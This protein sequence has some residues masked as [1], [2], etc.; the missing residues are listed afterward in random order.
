MWKTVISSSSI[1]SLAL[2]GDSL[3]YA[4]LPV[5]AETFGL[6]FAMVG[7]LLSINRFVR[8][9]TYGIINNLINKFGKR[10]MCILAAVLA[11]LST[12]TYGLSLGFISLFCARIIW[13]IAYS[14]LV[15][16]TLFY[17]VENKKRAGTKVGISQSIQRI[18]SIISLLVGT[19]YV[20]YVGPEMI[21]IIM[22][23]PTSLGVFIAF[24]LPKD[25]VNVSNVRNNKLQLRRPN[26]FECLYF[27]QG[28]GVD[29]LFAITITLMLAEKT[30][31][32]LAILG[33]GA[34]LALRHLGEAISSPVFGTIAD[35][36]GARRIFILSST[37][38]ILGF[39]LISIGMIITGAFILLIFRGAM[40][41]LGPTLIAQTITSEQKMKN[42]LS[43]M[44]T[45]RD[46]GAAIGPI[47]TGLTLS[48]LIPETQHLILGIIF[49]VFF[50][51]FLR[52]NT[53]IA[54]LKLTK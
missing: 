4:I 7:V 8:V 28:Y 20:T 52:S 47:I 36:I 30:E 15:L 1:M 27:L 9:F 54:N 12:A 11:T 50:L 21:F 45:Y 40:A 48:H 2:F 6:T 33:G 23:I 22:A 18:G 37:L 46:L 16:S 39:L 10:N 3:I 34:L 29:G 17:A 19:W 42:S 41:S 31:L 25:K 49:A 5:Y 14:I 44:Q 13:G 51:F 26:S 24:S 38:V 35:Y 53:Y 32:S 43:K